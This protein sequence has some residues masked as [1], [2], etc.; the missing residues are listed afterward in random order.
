[1]VVAICRVLQLACI[2]QTGLWSFI[3]AL[4]AWQA[5]YIYYVLVLST[6]VQIEQ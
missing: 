4:L 1:M 2:R 5:V 6:Y 3:I